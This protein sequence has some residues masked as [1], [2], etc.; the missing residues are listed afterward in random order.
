MPVPT[1]EM[2]EQCVP[3]S[4]M[5]SCAF[6]VHMIEMFLCVCMCVRVCVCLCVCVCVCACANVL[7]MYVQSYMHTTETVVIAV[8]LNLIIISQ[9]PQK[10]CCCMQIFD[11]IDMYICDR[12]DIEKDLS[13]GF[14]HLSFEFQGL[15][16]VI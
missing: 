12:M 3:V 4:P 15:V 2:Q 9:T 5:H 10:F 13:G 11:T 1:H 14:D 7:C 6:F 8:S 16:Y